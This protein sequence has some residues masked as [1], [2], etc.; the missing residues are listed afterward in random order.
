MT[1]PDYPSDPVSFSNPTLSKHDN[2]EQI[3]RRYNMFSKTLAT[4]AEDVLYERATELQLETE[5]QIVP[6]FPIPF[7]PHISDSEF[8]ELAYIRMSE[9]WWGRS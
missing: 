3:M 5:L 1:G 9:K 6:P 2:E 8:F 4:P 7:I